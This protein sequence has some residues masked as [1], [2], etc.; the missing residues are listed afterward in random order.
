[1]GM[2]AGTVALDGSN[3][4]TGSG[5]ALAIAQSLGPLLEAQSLTDFQN[6]GLSGVNTSSLSTQ[7]I[8]QIRNSVCVL[9]NG[10]ASAIVPYIHLNAVAHVST[11]D[12]TTIVGQAT[13]VDL[14]I[15]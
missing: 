5:L 14:P 3:N 13:P 2:S 1:M 10:F 8:I 9:A 12:E 6:A 15:L 4:Y 7:T 11:A